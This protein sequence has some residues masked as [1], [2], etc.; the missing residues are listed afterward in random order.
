M[1]LTFLFEGLI[2]AQ[3]ELNFVYVRRFKLFFPGSICIMLACDK[4][5]LS[6]CTPSFNL[7]CRFI[8]VQLRSP[9]VSM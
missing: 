7:L 8:V 5:R 6:P 2:P 4:L 1:F 9:N 3:E